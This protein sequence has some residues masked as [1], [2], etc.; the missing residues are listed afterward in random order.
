M[1][2]WGF[3]GRQSPIRVQGQKLGRRS[4]DLG[5][6]ETSSPVAETISLNEHA[7]F[8]AALMNL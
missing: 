5:N 3:E 2:Q 4:G 7:I 8:V 1:E 6:M